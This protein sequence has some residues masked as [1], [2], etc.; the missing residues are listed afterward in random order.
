MIEDG[1]KAVDS[2]IGQRTAA[3]VI[4]ATKHCMGVVRVKRTIDGR[5]QPQFPI[6]SLGYRR[7]ILRQ[8]GVL[9]PDGP[10]GPVMDFTQ[11]ADHTFLDALT[12]PFVATTR[13]VRQQ[14][15]GDLRFPCSPHHLAPL[16][17]AIGDRFVYRDVLTALHRGDRDGR[18]QMVGGH[19][20]HRIHVGLFVQQ[21]AK[22]G[23]GRAGAKRLTSPLIGVIRI[24]HLASHLP[25]A[26]TA[27]HPFSPSWIAQVFADTLSN[28]VQTPFDVVLTVGIR[29][30][31]RNDLDLRVRQQ[32]AQ[33]AEPLSSHSDMSERDLF[34]GGHM[35]G[36]TQYV[37]RQN[38]E[39]TGSNSGTHKRAAVEL[40]THGISP[41][42]AGE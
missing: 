11:R 18:V 30:T 16:K 5:P 14:V 1:P 9:R 24:D 25:S 39:D 31:D 15:R 23:I 32:I 2:H 38:G 33:L 3:K 41:H 7:A 42:A 13:S 26:G 34:R 19:D 35:S 8:L 28:A 4:P 27:R 20:L 6:K 29:V 21:F 36:P 37:A 17:Q 12:D 10:I 22:V 40:E